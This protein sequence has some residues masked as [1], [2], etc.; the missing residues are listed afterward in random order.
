[1]VRNNIISATNANRLYW[2]GR[3]EE[4]VYLT[5]HLLRKCHDKMI[6]GEPDDYNTFWRKLDS[7]NNYTTR[8][9]FSFGMMF[10]DKNLSSVLSAQLAA[11]D[12]AMMLRGYIATETLAYLEMSITLMR[13]LKE[14]RE[15]NITALQPVTDWSMA[16]WG[17]CGERITNRKVIV[18]MLAGRKLENLDMFIRFDYDA[19]RI[20]GTFN[21]LVTHLNEVPALYDN[22][23][24]E[25]I[26]NM[27][28]SY[29]ENCYKTDYR[30]KLL[31]LINILVRV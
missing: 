29:T 27:L 3:Y 28:A 23:V 31:K 21:T 16:F 15:M 10:D 25:E 9:E 1:M 5:L 12:N 20:M 6:D 30:D 19:E 22:H 4:R 18:L 7:S 2:L 13:R 8:E 24:L 17:N 11:L 26:Q 14:A